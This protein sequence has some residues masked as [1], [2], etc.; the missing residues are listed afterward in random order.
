M[1]WIGEMFRARALPRRIPQHAMKTIAMIK[2][3]DEVV[4]MAE[5]IVLGP[6]GIWSHQT[7]AV[8]LIKEAIV[9]LKVI[10]AIGNA[11]GLMKD[12]MN[13]GPT[14]VIRINIVIDPQPELLGSML[15]RVTIQKESLGNGAK[16]RHLN[17]LKNPDVIG[18]IKIIVSHKLFNW[19]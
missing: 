7:D 3:L 19:K 5:T 1:T 18:V 16:K 10:R 6:A 4:L 14:I 15:E 8:A 9:W 17:P 11:G 2:K 12:M 13:Q